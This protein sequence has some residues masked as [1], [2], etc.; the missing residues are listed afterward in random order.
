MFILPM[1]QLQAHKLMTSQRW[2]CVEYLRPT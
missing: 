2:L 1:T